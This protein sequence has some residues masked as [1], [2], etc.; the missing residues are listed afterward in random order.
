MQSFFFSLRK[1]ENYYILPIEVS[2]FFKISANSRS[3][4]G[5]STIALHEKNIYSFKIIFEARFEALKGYS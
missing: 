3:H 2:D 5:Q 4:G 1:L